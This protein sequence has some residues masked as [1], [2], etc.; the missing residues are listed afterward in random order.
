M[1]DSMDIPE[2]MRWLVLDDFVNV[3]NEA[4]IVI[5]SGYKII[6]INVAALKIFNYQVEEILGQQLSYIIPERFIELH[7]KHIQSFYEGVEVARRMGNGKEM[8]G[9]RKDGSEFPIEASIARVTRAGKTNFLVFLQDLTNQK[10]IEQNLLPWAQVFQYA[11]WGVA[12]G[13]AEATS[14]EL[15]NPAFA[16]MHGYTVEELANIPIRDLYAPEERDK[17]G[18]FLKLAQD[19]GNVTFES[20]HVCKDGTVFPVLITATTVKNEKG[21]PLYRVVN[22]QDITAQKQYERE[23][24]RRQSI[25]EAVAFAA[26]KFLQ[27]GDPWEKNI[28]EI[29]ERLGKATGVDRVIIFKNITGENGDLKMSLKYEWVGER[30]VSRLLNSNFQNISYLLDGFE[31][32]KDLL[33]NRQVVQGNVEEM[34]ERERNYLI[35]QNLKSYIVVP[36]FVG[37]DWWGLIKLDDCQSKHEWSA[38][39][40]DALKIASRL[41][42]AAILHSEMEIALNESEKRY[43]YLVE[44]MNE[45]VWRIDKDGFTTFANRRLAEMLGYTPEEMM[46]RHPFSFIADQNLAD[47]EEKL[48]HRMQGI[49]DKHNFEFLHKNG[50]P[51]LTS[52]STVPIMDELGYYNGTIASLLDISDLRKAQEALKESEARNAAVIATMEEGVVIQDADG[53]IIA[54]NAAAERIL[55][56]TEDQMKG[57]TSFDPR[58]QALLEDGTPA[59]G[60]AHPAVVSLRTGKPVSKFVMGVHK[61]DN[62]LT[63]TSVNS[64]PLFHPGEEKPYAVHVTFSDITERRQMYQ[65]M[66]NSVEK[67]TQELMTLLE[68]SRTVASTMELN[69]QLTLILKQLRTVVDYTGAGIVVPEGDHFVM[70]EYEGPTPREQMVDQPFQ[71]TTSVGYQRV[72]DTRKPFI[73]SDLR[74]DDACVLSLPTQ[75]KDLLQEKAFNARSWLGLPMIVKDKLIGLVRL[76]HAEPNRFTEEHARL[77]LV[78]AEQAAIAIEKTRLYER[79]QKLAALEE[80]QKLARELHDSVSQALYGIAL[81]TRTARTLVER[82]PAKAIEPL[83]YSLALAEAALAEMRALI[84]ELRPESLEKEGLTGAITKQADALRARHSIQVEIDICEE[85]ST[86]LIVKEAL[87]RISQEAFNN[88][89]KHAH[90]SRVDL[91]LDHLGDDLI[92]EITDNGQGFNLASSYPGHL[93]LNSMQERA[94]RVGGKFRIESVPGKGTIIQVEVPISFKNEA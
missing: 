27:K 17:V 94:K 79:A 18:R 5:D 8:F 49:A 85:P 63:W 84:F 31:K 88:I 41:L 42:G 80:R 58:W 52:V 78:F 53:H 76:D 81:G 11:D 54:C 70:I 40:V 21:K 29:L 48:K 20:L 37:E 64:Q 67:R 71:S 3:I 46:G 19:M 69:V 77:G 32:W 50:S 56:L 72:V 1:E 13:R 93:G 73:I 6:F 89:I 65:L 43:S 39:F 55:G 10:Q 23:L 34:P 86:P 15:M 74:E 92:L 62:T 12:F 87:Y 90:A 36:V 7:K 22:I 28:Q 61:P 51:V 60:E 14:M 57:S 45:G 33:E 30:T 47:A 25:L 82:D 75:T 35:A 26:E 83:D 4:M 66:E 91:K 38:I 68:L 44:N 2:S 9:R 59:P 16:R 24:I